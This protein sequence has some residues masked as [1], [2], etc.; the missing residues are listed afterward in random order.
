M[1]LIRESIS[2][3]ERELGV[4]VRITHLRRVIGSGDELFTRYELDDA[5]ARAD[6]IN[7]LLRLGAVDGECKR[8]PLNPYGGKTIVRLVNGEHVV[9]EGI[10]RC[11][12]DDRYVKQTGAMIGLLRALNDM[13]DRRQPRVVLA[14][15][16]LLP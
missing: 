15:E 5:N 8:A 3:V 12:D 7:A 14:L 4:R 11:R 9:G 2:H 1:T 16:L 13:R 10:A 6:V